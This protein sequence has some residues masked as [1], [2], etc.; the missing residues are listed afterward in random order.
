MSS[1]FMPA[2]GPGAVN[3]LWWHRGN[4]ES[5]RLDP[6]DA[7]G[8]FAIALAGFAHQDAAG[9]AEVRERLTCRRFAPSCPTGI[10][11][12][13]VSKSARSRARSEI[14]PDAH[15]RYAD[16]LTVAEARAH[17]PELDPFPLV[18]P[19]IHLRRRRPD[20]GCR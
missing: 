10:S 20:A 19:S 18:T 11:E 7:P 16:R 4:V 17:Y 14:R 2:T 5:V 13:R 8:E 1:I 3:Y 6:L 15:I 9:A 12:A